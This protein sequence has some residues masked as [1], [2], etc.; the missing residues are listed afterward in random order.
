MSELPAKA[1]TVNVETQRFWDATADGRIELPRCDDCGL[2]IWYPRAICPDCQSTALT[3]ETMAGT[4]TVYSYTIA[5]SGVGRR[6]R[7]HLPFVVAY[8]RLDEGPTMLTNVVDCDPEAVTIGLPVAAVFDDT[9][10]G[11]ALVRFRPV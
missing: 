3:W 5:R 4:G 9:G 1:P 6:W 2:V 7:E 11:S 10:E 8:V